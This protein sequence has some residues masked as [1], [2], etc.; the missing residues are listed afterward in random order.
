LGTGLD[1]SS[2]SEN[3]SVSKGL[4]N[5]IH[6]RRSIRLKDYD[7]TQ[8]GAY[9][10]TICAYQ[11]AC[12]FGKIA[13]DEVILTEIGRVVQEEW[14]QTAVLRPYIA[15]DMFV[16]MPNHFHGIIVIAEEISGDKKGTI[17]RAPTPRQFG[18]PIARSL[19]TIVG[20]YKAAVTRRV[21]K[22]HSANPLWQRNYHEHIIRNE[23]DLDR[24]RAYIETNPARWQADSLYH[25]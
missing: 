3:L 21:N 13:N 2:P 9:F 15:L 12:V 22:G 17:H 10:V 5:M 8:E 25:E 24:L 4:L 18:I 7:Y 14:E 23:T 16:V 6:N 20:T 1:T 19:S 11:R